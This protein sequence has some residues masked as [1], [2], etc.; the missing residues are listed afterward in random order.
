MP[1]RRMAEIIRREKEVRAHD[2]LARSVIGRKEAHGKG[3][4]RRRGAQ[5]L[6]NLE[7]R[8]VDRKLRT[9]RAAEREARE[10]TKR[11]AHERTN[12]P[13]ERRRRENSSSLK[14]LEV[15]ANRTSWY[16]RY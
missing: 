14:R 3:D 1:Q 12:S 7:R 8:R 5:H 15:Q 4:A 2:V 6:I 13:E 11:E 10:R 16:G 9:T